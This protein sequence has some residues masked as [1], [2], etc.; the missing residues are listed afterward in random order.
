MVSSTLKRKTRADDHAAEEDAA[1][2][3]GLV[4]ISS[5]LE[6]A[7]SMPD[8]NDHQEKTAPS[9]DP[10]LDL[11]PD[12]DDDVSSPRELSV[13]QE[14]VLAPAK[15]KNSRKAATAKA[16]KKKATK[17]KVPT[18]AEFNKMRSR[19]LDFIV[20]DDDIEREFKI[21]NVIFVLPDDPDLVKGM[22]KGD[23]GFTVHELWKVRILNI[24][25]DRDG[26]TW[27]LIRW[28]WSK[29][30]LVKGNRENKWELSKSFL[31]AIGKNE[32]IECDHTDIISY[33][34]CEASV[35][36]RFVDFSDVNQENP[37]SFYSRSNLIVGWSNNKAKVK[38]ERHTCLES[39][40]GSKFCTKTYH[41]D[42][43]I[44]HFCATCDRWYH[45]G[46]MERENWGPRSAQEVAEEFGD[47]AIDLVEKVTPWEKHQDNLRAAFIAPNKKGR[48][49]SNNSSRNTRSSIPKS[50]KS[51]GG[52]VPR[53]SSA[54]KR[55]PPSVI[56]AV[57]QMQILRGS[58]TKYGVV[59]NAKLVCS[60]RLVV[61]DFAL[62]R[63]SS[64]DLNPDWL[65][66]IE[67]Q[68]KPRTKG[69]YL[70]GQ[71]QSLI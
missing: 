64:G 17:L 66:K 37:H 68:K 59:G 38:G 27:L 24:K 5:Q 36:L 57:A 19:Q 29:E 42:T 10:V 70:C 51:V 40:K 6:P 4:P 49:A 39:G 2:D 30:D 41:P 23:R 58:G 34:S 16:A 63:M 54:V 52:P 60:A 22:T 13:D 69:Y 46:C 31:N 47:A 32:L 25:E 12:S 15:T 56:R 67:S 71:C 33:E 53:H 14:A 20:Q 18:E 55:V 43:D 11:N 61:E 48:L 45:V 44:Q 9:S 65:A 8:L 35:E 28:F 26:Y 1:V 7:E 62:G 3:D 21:N 50:K